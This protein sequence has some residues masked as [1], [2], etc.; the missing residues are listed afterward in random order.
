MMGRSIPPSCAQVP[1]P[2]VQVLLGSSAKH[3]HRSG[4]RSWAACAAPSLLPYSCAL[5]L[6]LGTDTLCLAG[7]K[8]RKEFQLLVDQVSKRWKRGGKRTAESALD[9]AER[10]PGKEDAARELP[11]GTGGWCVTQTPPEPHC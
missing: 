7:S 5:C 3:S 11:A 10:A 4:A 8:H 9:T 2:A 1:F 6:V